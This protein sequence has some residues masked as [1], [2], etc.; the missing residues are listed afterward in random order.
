MSNFSAPRVTIILVYIVM[1]G[2]VVTFLFTTIKFYLATRPVQALISSTE[3]VQ[4]WR[5][6]VGFDLLGY[7]FDVDHVILTTDSVEKRQE[8][9]RIISF[10]LPSVTYSEPTNTETGKRV[11]E[12][13][14]KINYGSVD[15]SDAGVLIRVKNQKQQTKILVT[16]AVILFSILL[17]ALYWLWNFRKL[18]SGISA[19]DLQFKGENVFRLRLLGILLLTVAVAQ[20][21]FELGVNFY[22]FNNF[23]LVHSGNIEPKFNF[24]FVMSAFGLTLISL[25]EVIKHGITIKEDQDLT[26]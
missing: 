22:V 17:L 20:L 16:I 13:D 5:Y 12:D 8:Y 15:F 25:S 4:Q 21:L 10:E 1:I 6:H 23:K 14:Y 24:Q 18:I 19:H 9:Y 3:G 11:L 2:L 26:I 7:K